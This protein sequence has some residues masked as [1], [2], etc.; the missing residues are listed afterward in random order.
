MD[1][2]RGA[3]RLAVAVLLVGLGLGH[4]FFGLANFGFVERLPEN[5][6]VLVEGVSACIAAGSLL[7]A[8]ADQVRRKPWAS[9]VV[10]GAVVFVLGMAL[11]ISTGASTPEMMQVVLPVLLVS[12]VKLILE[13]RA[14]WT[15]N[16]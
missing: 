11:S 14:S 2:S 13:K 8:A 7:W 5:L 1:R 12:G 6:D 15:S 3:A 16:S 9:K 4:F 10:F